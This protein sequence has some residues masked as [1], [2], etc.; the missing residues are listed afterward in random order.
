MA[1]L[2]QAGTTGGAAMAPARGGS[3]WG[4]GG[5]MSMPRW[6]GRM[7]PGAAPRCSGARLRKSGAAGGAMCVSAPGG[8]MS[9][10][11]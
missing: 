8:S 1:G 11:W 9:M 7:A 5:S 4:A 10:T 2:R 3:A 6:S